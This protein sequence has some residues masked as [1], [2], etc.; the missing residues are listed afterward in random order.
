M[1]ENIIG[2]AIL[3]P[4][5]ILLWIGVVALLVLFLGRLMGV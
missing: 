1:L 5:I 2:W 3:I 4:V